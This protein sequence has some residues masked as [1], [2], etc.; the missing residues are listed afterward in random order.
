MASTTSTGTGSSVHIAIVRKA[1]RRVR[2]APILSVS[3]ASAPQQNAC[4][5]PAFGAD[6]CGPA[7]RRAAANRGNRHQHTMFGE[8]GQK[9]LAQLHVVADVDA[10]V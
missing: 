5:P 10:D 3:E 9:R 8:A 1:R 2:C 6:R 4:R 7:Q